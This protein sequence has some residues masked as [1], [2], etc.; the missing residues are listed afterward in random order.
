MVLDLSV[1]EQ[2]YVEDCEGC[3]APIRVRYRVEDGAVV[4]LEVSDSAQ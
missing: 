3:C 4:E 2:Q 1:P